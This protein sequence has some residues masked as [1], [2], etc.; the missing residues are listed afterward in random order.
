V[1]GNRAAQLK[2][3]LGTTLLISDGAMGTI[4]SAGGHAGR[5]LELLNIEQPDLV[6]A[7]H[8]AYV[9]A[10]SDLT[11]TN[12]FQG[13]SVT[14]ARHGLADRLVELNAA[15]VTLAREAAGDAVFVGGDMGPTGQIL[16]PYGEF[17]IDTAREAFAEQSRVL[18][19]A[20][21]DC[22]VFETFS[23]LGE[24]RLAVEA[25]V[26]TGLPVIASLSFDPSGRTAFGVTPGQAAEQLAAAGAAVVGTNCGTVTPIEMVG[27]IASFRAATDL[28][29]IA[30]PNAGRP[31]QTATGVT[32]PETPDSFAEAAVRL[33]EA[34]A[35]IIGG[36]CGSTPEH[37]RAIV[38][39]LKPS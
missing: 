10:G 26:E 18:A 34:G 7:A 20:G 24:I 3:K 25:A 9:E 38:S 28:P 2:S 12:T 37:V 17:P 21:V 11:L 23:D 31:Q 1:S 36:C 29:L 30:Q 16:E 15:A 14:L 8:H 13:N 6:R 22:L 32:W 19:D 5:A 35:T 27:V 4:L 33:R 39:R